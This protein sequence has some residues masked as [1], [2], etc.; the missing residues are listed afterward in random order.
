[1]E[2]VGEAVVC[3]GKEDVVTVVVLLPGGPP[4]F[5]V[6]EKFT[7]VTL[8]VEGGELPVAVDVLV[9]PETV[10]A[11]GSVVDVGEVEPP[12]EVDEVIVVVVVVG[13]VVV[14]MSASSADPHTSSIALT[15][16]LWRSL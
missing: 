14:I 8:V 7:G 16:V 5:V 15:T 11:E 13:V 2:V 3:P 12:A 1:M 4:V 10:V 9:P 6:V